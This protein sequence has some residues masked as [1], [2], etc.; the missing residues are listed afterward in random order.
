VELLDKIAGTFDDTLSLILQENLANNGIEFRLAT[1][2]VGIENGSVTVEKDG[3]TEKINADKVL[4]SI[5]RR[6]VTDG[7]GL[8]NIGVYLERGAVVTD[9]CMRTN[10]PGVYAA[11]DINGK[12]MLAHTAYREAEVAVNNILGKKDIMNYHVIPSVIYTSTEAASVGETEET[13]KAHGFVYEKKEMSMAYS[14]RYIA[15]ND[16]L[17]GIIKIIIEKSSQR[18]LGVQLI[19]SYASEIILAAGVMIESRLPVES[20][21]K[22]IFPHPTVGEIIRETIFS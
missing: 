13:A 6:S 5:G 14:G 20:L 8:D 11:G 22:I 12:S 18:L 17:D 3:M 15:E 1:R 7:I 19:G 16:R 9:N 21:R 2:F 10:I 4:I